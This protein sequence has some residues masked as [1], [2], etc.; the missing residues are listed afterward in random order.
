MRSFARIAVLVLTLAA[1][2]ACGSDKSTGPVSVV[3]GTWTGSGAFQ[4]LTIDVT[5]NLKHNAGDTVVSG[6]GSLSGGGQVIDFTVDGVF[7]APDVV[8]TL[9][10]PPYQ[11][12]SYTAKLSGNQMTGILDGSGLDS[13]S[14]T[15]TRQ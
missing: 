2:G 11:P 5:A 15:L 9:G 1:L 14:V 10:I 4:G 7:K 12:I 13:V 3:N 8:L 6:S